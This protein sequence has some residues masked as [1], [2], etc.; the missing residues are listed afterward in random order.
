MSHTES[1]LQ[2]IIDDVLHQ[3]KVDAGSTFNIDKI[4]LAEFSRRSGISRAKARKLKADGFIV[5]PHAR[6]GKKVKSTK[7]QPF[8]AL[9]CSMLSDNKS[10]SQVIFEKILELGYKG[11]LTTVKNYIQD[12][13]HLIPPKRKVAEA[14]KVT[15]RYGTNPGEA[16]EMDWGFVDCV[17]SKGTTKRVCCLAIICHHCSS[18]YVEFFTSAR[19]E[20]LFIGM[21]HAFEYLG[22]P[23]KVLTD[24]MKSVVDGR[25]SAGRPIFNRDYDAFQ[26]LVGFKT[27][28]CKPYHPYTKGSTERL[29]RYVKQNFVVGLTY[30]KDLTELNEKVLLWSDKINSKVRAYSDEPRKDIH[31]HSCREKTRKLIYTKELCSYLCPRRRISSDRFVT[32]EGRRFGVPLTYVG[33]TCRIS[34]KGGIITI[35]SEDLARDLVYY[36]VTWLKRDSY[37]PDQFG[38]ITESLNLPNVTGLLPKD[39]EQPTS[40][41]RSKIMVE[42]PANSVPDTDSRWNKFAQTGGL[43]C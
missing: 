11:S 36:P 40:P 28:L 24:N 16:Y 10:N 19:R 12:H 27:K 41:V 34:R 29:V 37:C 1:G 23:D 25:D 9:I 32:F 43:A 8:E 7:I 6:I 42:E 22:I 20:N 30:I 26:K 3:M 5:K 2:A 14:P 13:K 17:D 38:E 18:I 4:N 15:V 31:L 39:S 21:L 33:T 35:K